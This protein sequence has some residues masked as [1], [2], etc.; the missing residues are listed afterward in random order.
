MLKLRD[1]CEVAKVTV[2]VSVP[3]IL[4]RIAESIRN[5]FIELKMP[6]F[7]HP[8]V[9]AKVRESFGG[10]LRMIA[11]GSAPLGTENMIYLE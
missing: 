8:A 5:K 6:V 4:N 9:F 2:L 3:R 7:K 11:T 1:D 10:K